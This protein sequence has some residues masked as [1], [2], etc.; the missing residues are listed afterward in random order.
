MHKYFSYHYQQ[1]HENINNI[2][3]KQ[4]TIPTQNPRNYFML[5]FSGRGKEV[6]MLFYVQNM[7][8]QMRYFYMLY[9]EI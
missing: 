3:K 5:Q 1:Q 4:N 6:F 9:D 8:E 7:K 2:Q